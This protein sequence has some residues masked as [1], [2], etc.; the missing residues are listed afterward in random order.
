MGS[1]E[2][3]GQDPLADHS[4]WDPGGCYRLP[5]GKVSRLGLED[6]STGGH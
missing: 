3:L 4:G 5:G 6:G 1:R 2:V